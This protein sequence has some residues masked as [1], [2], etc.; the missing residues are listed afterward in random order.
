[1]RWISVFVGLLASSLLDSEV[2]G[3]V[4]LLAFGVRASASP[5]EAADLIGGLF[6]VGLITNIL[7]YHHPIFDIMGDDTHSRL[8]KAL[9]DEGMTQ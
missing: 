4:N 2:G 6:P 8:E 9:R 7:G 1:M 3:Q 5:I